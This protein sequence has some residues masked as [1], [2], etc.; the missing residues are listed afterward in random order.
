MEEFIEPL[1]RAFRLLQE[2]TA[3]LVA[4]AAHDPAEGAAAAS[5][6]L[7]MLG[8][9]ALG[10]LWARMAERALGGTLG[11][12]EDIAFYA[13]KLTTARFFMRRVLPETAGLAI[14]IRG[15]GVPV[16]A[17]DEL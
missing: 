15:G 3:W 11:S 5:D 6:Y 12:G 8:L 14:A 17:G 10:Y 13:G 1:A 2:A 4:K 9:V 7:R 16:A